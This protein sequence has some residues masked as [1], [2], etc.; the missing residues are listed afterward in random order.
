MGIQK[1]DSALI[2]GLGQ[3]VYSNDGKYY[4]SLTSKIIGLTD[5]YI[6]NFDRTTGLLSNQLSEILLDTCF[7]PGVAISPNNRFL[8]LSLLDNIY[9]YDLQASDVLASKTLV[10]TYDGYTSP[11]TI[12]GFEFWCT[13]G[14]LALGPDGRIYISGVGQYIEMGVIQYPDSKGLACDVRQHS[15]NKTSQSQGIPNNPN[16][17]LGPLDGSPADTLGIDNI[18][19]ANFRADQD[20]LDYLDFQFQDLSYYE[21]STWSWDFGDGTTSSDTSP[22]HSY[23]KQGVYVVCLTVSNIN[24]TSTICDTLVLGTNHTSGSASLKEIL[25]FPNPASDQVKFIIN[26]YYPVKAS[27]RLMDSNGKQVLIKQVFHGWNDI[28]VEDLPKGMY[29][30]DIADEGVRIYSGKLMAQ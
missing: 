5:L 16:Y 27:L 8:Y 13:F 1:L 11:K 17:R 25:V 29:Y 24:G 6:F 15:I 3:A 19:V 28:D 26:D 4:C 14:P 20:T 10:A 18:P 22:V 21:P 9:Q 7:T 30:Y 12:S 2:D 23:A